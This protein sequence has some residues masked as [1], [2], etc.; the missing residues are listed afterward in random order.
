M[1]TLRIHGSEYHYESHGPK[2]VPAILLSPLLY[3]D[4][5]VFDTMVSRL[6]DHYHVVTYDH[7]GTGKSGGHSSPSL[8]NSA[9]DVASLIE[10]LEIE[11]C[12]FVG[13]CL[14]A[15]VGL[16]LA[17]HRP[18]LLR[19]CTFMG[20]TG[21]PDKAEM[22]EEGDDFVRKAKREGMKAH[23]EEF[24]KM[25]FGPSFLATQDP[26]S[27][28]RREKWIHHLGTIKP[29]EIE[30]VLQ[31]I[32]RRDL[33]SKLSKVQCPVLVMAGSEEPKDSLD[34]Y[35]RF[36]DR[37]PNAEFRL[38]PNAGYALVIERPDEVV[39]HIK[40]FIGNV[41]RKAKERQRQAPRIDDIRP[42]L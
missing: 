2:G 41:E 4:T 26:I 21:E 38:I 17:V 22:V 13:N 6:S 23:A 34:A 11:Q 31:I 27:K 24:A 7:R 1:A 18:D 33:S 29:T 14:G 16:Q 37:L 12:H 35:R 20:V 9:H 25:W 42:Q 39:E 32:H 15:F 3:T 5:G 19:S 10:D 28:A 30:S 36:V 40:Y 8:E